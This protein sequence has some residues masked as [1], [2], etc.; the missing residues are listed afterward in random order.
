MRADVTQTQEGSQYS[1]VTSRLLPWATG[2]H[3][4]CRVCSGKQ[5]RV[6]IE[7]LFWSCGDT[8][9]LRLVSTTF[10]SL[11]LYGHRFSKAYWAR[12]SCFYPQA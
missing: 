4:P 5:F 9:H 2:P 3:S 12:I 7:G 1:C 8:P 10:P 6:E 11:Y